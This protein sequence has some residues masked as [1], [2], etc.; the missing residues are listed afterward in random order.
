[1]SPKTVIVPL[2]CLFPCA[3]DVQDNVPP[4]VDFSFG[5]PASTM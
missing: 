1:M 2:V 3:P 5:I 4:D